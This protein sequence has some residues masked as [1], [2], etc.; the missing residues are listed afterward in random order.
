MAI[1]S[2]FKKRLV[3][4]VDRVRPTFSA[5]TRTESTETGLPAWIAYRERVRREPWGDVVVSQTVV[6]LKADADVQKGDE[7]IVDGEQRPI[8]KLIKARVKNG[9]V[10][11]LEATLE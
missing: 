6:F 3:L 2:A 1:R 4:T 10:H 5:G 11:H 7:L 8:A 9:I